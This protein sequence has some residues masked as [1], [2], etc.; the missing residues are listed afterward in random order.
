MSLFIVTKI[1]LVGASKTFTGK[2]IS[3]W[4]T[5]SN[6][7]GIGSA[8]VKL[9]H[10]LLTL[11]TNFIQFSLNTLRSF[12]TQN[13]VQISIKSDFNKRNSAIFLQGIM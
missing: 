13:S 10:C 8:S 12:S 7:Q 6:L 2:N 5:D 1:N 11:G 3:N 4:C 9:H